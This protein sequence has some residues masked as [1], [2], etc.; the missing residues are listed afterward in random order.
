[1]KKRKGI[2]IGIIVAAVLLAGSAIAWFTAGDI[3]A[4]TFAMMTKSGTEYFRWVSDRQTDR[5][6]SRIRLAGKAMDAVDR[7]SQLTGSGGQATDGKAPETVGKDKSVRTRAV[8]DVSDEL[9]DMLG[10]VHFKR[11]E[12]V[13]AL[14]V[15]DGTISIELVPRY[16]DRDLLK[17]RLLANPAENV[18]YAQIPTYREDLI[19]MSSLYETLGISGMSLEDIIARLNEGIDEDSKSSG[20]TPALTITPDKF[21]DTYTRCCK[22]L[23][24]SFEEAI[25]EKKC[26]VSRVDGEKTK[27][28]RVTVRTSTEL[29]D[30]QINGVLSVLKE[31]GVLP[32]TGQFAGIW[33]ELRQM[34]GPDAKGECDLYI[35]NR[36]N[37]CGGEL[38]VAVKATKVAIT[39][40]D[41]DNGIDA[42]VGINSINALTLGLSGER[43][44]GRMYAK[45]V[46]RPEAF[47]KALMGD[48]GVLSFELG[49]EFG[50]HD[51]ML[52]AVAYDGT[53]QVGRAGLT[54]ETGEYTGDVLKTEGLKAY[55]ID[56]LTE[57]AYF[58]MTALAELALDILDEVDEEFVN[59]YVI[60][61]I[62]PLLGDLADLDAIRSIVDTGM[63]DMFSGTGPAIGEEPEPEPEP[64]IPGIECVAPDEFVPEKWEYPAAADRFG[65][66]YTDLAEY[67]DM[68]KYKGIV[69]AVP[70]SDGI[71]Q[72]QLDERK[73]SFLAK[74]EGVFFEDGRTVSVQDGDE[75]Y[76]DI[77][78][79]LGGFPIT[80]YAYYDCY[81]LMGLDQYGE[82]L[83]AKLIGMHIGEIR[84]V[85]ATLGE[86]FE[87]FAGYTGIFRV[88]LK[89]IVREIKPAWTEA[90]VCGCL[91]YDSLASCEQEL[92]NQLILEADVSEEA[93]KAVLVNMV[94]DG[95]SIS[96]PSEEAMNSLRQREYDRLYLQ[97]I[98]EGRSPI[99][100]YLL[101]GKTVENLVAD[102]DAA[103]N[104]ELRK[105]CFYGAIAQAEGIT[106]GGAELATA[107][108]ACMSEYGCAT[109]DEL[110]EFITLDE[111]ADR[112]IEKRID[113]MIYDTAVISYK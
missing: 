43:R 58:D 21:A 46:L 73:R 87:D 79:M 99:Q 100:Q 101:E 65:Y 94:W 80:A 10:L 62:S 25:V 77:M 7:L 72:A 3:I 51:W 49:T 37:I 105:H 9:A 90:F 22:F 103:I 5:N 27:Y 47:I 23:T 4:N 96:R 91:K 60:S 16:N 42:L 68:A 17:L 76:F 89:K 11:D 6:A 92:L 12:I 13:S 2:I 112:E 14:T 110:M 113:Q 93:V 95:T 70:V 81:E 15:H 82:G 50:E 20:D 26:E 61:L 83:D 33:K 64:T 67:A 109:F 1:M 24:E 97:T 107:V 36:G 52:E 85:E 74:Y 31:D 104:P 41:K 30:S 32:K 106:L 98:G 63:L 54:C 84:D 71:T 48:A 57:S 53:K 29:L 55:S 45:A 59:D 28:T 8:L 35:D 44:D 66:S 102:M 34:A 19:E 69:Y 56:T 78:P 38:R 75:I 88:T 111:I 40:F 108:D 39:Y 86:Q 18:L